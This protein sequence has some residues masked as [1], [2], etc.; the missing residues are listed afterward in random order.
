MTELTDK[1][2]ADRVVALGIVEQPYKRIDRYYLD[3][4]F[5]DG[6]YNVVRDWR[7]A[8]A[9]MR[10]CSQMR[11]QKNKDQNMR[12]AVTARSWHGKE[13]VSESYN[14]ERAIIE[15]CVKALDEQSE[16]E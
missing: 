4:G 13:G 10:K 2:L 1:E 11:I 5:I 3:R 7:I 12:T 14:D 8:G 15:A 9:L 16:D 6:P